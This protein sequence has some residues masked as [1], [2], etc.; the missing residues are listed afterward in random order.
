MSQPFK[1]VVS[2]FHL[3][4]GP[5]SSVNPLE[6]FTTD[7]AFGELLDQVAAESQTSGADVELILNGDIFEMLQ[8]P[9]VDGFDPTARYPASSYRDTS[10]PESRRKMDIIAH[11][12][13]GFFDALRRFLDPG[14]PRR[15]AVFLKGNH[16]LELYWPAVQQRIR[17]AVD[18]VGARAG[19][20]HFE[21]LF[22]SRDGIYVEHGNQYSEFVNQVPDMV[23]PVDPDD[24]E[25]LTWPPG[26]RFVTDFFNE[27]ERE[28]YWVD[29]VKPITALI[30]YALAYDFVFAAR[31]LRVL[32]RAL[33]GI[34]E[35]LLGLDVAEEEPLLRQLDD[36]EGMTDLAERYEE[37]PAFR[38]QFN[39]DVMQLISPPITGE[40]DAIPRAALAEPTAIG[41]AVQQDV[42]S[43]LYDAAR[44]L[45]ARE[46][47]TVVT[48]GH[49]HEPGVEPLPGG[50]VYVNT[51]TWTWSGDFTQAGENTWR[52]LFREPEQYTGQRNLAYLRIDYDAEGRP[53]AQLL[54]HPTPPLEGDEELVSGL[55]SVWDRFVA[56][57]RG[58]W[59]R[60]LGAR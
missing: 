59:Q 47:A 56:W 35:G 17:A 49:T 11:G 25:R 4:G 26:S 37:D 29:G 7:L 40:A 21:P 14:P 53:S 22:I 34:V 9:H 41:E 8:V 6:D 5:P 23:R 20:L 51:G 36:P 2:D 24:P 12:H 38:A 15:T 33:P 48:F 13:A 27:V 60:L 19:L 55:R 54:R 1:I 3:G 39:A 52:D 30:W 32:L 58:L 50:A 10:E 45:A 18:A 44:D 46:G 31:A 16:D 42:R 43:A 57:L 28:R